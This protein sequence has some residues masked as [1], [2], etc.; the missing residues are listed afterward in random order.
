M[1]K[2]GY[3]FGLFISADCAGVCFCA[4]SGIGRLY[5]DNAVIKGMSGKLQL[6]VT[7]LGCAFFPVIFAVI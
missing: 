3:G 7:V 6:F 4:V 5:G 2:L 1:S